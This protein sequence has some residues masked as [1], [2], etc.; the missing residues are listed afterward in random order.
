MA[1]GNSYSRYWRGVVWWGFCLF[2]RFTV[3]HGSVKALARTG[4]WPRHPDASRSMR[5]WQVSEKLRTPLV[6]L[7]C[8]VPKPIAPVGPIAAP[9][10]AAARR[11]RRKQR[12]ELREQIGSGGMGT[13]YRAFDREL[14]RTVAVKVLHPEL[15]SSL[16]NLLRLKRELVLASRVSDRHVVR[17]HDLGEIAG[18][19]LIAMDWVDGESL[20]A[21]LD[22]VHTLP[23][24]QVWNFA[25]QISQ[26]LKAIHTA[27]IVHRDLK[28]ANLLIARDGEILLT[29][30]GLAK[31]ALPQDFTLS[32]SGETSG[33]PRYMAPEQLAGLPADARSDLYSLGLVLL[34]MLTGTTA[35]ESLGG[36]RERLLASPRG[37]HALSEELRQFAALELVIRRC[38]Q[39]NRAERYAS[40]D[41][42]L[43]G[44]ALALREAAPAR[45]QRIRPAVFWMAAL[46]V[47]ALISLAMW[48]PWAPR[49][50][51]PRPDQLYAAAIGLMSPRAGAA[52]LTAALERLDQ[53]LG[54]HPDH[55]PAAGA[56]LDALIR[57]YEISGDPAWLR[58]ARHG[59]ATAAARKFTATQRALFQARIDL[60]DGMYREVIRRLEADTVL[61]NRSS[62]ANLLLGRA[63]EASGESDRALASYRIAVRL[64]PES[65]L[66]HNDLGSALLGLGR[67]EDARREFVRVT[68]LNPEEPTGYCNL[69]VSFLESGDLANAR[70]N[71][72]IALQRAPASE[73]YY[74]LGVTAYFAREYA[75]SIPFFES[76]IRIRPNFERYVLGLADA[77]RRSDRPGLARESYLHALALLDELARSRPLDMQEV[78]RRALCFAR[79]GDYAAAALALDAAADP[80][81]REI[82][83]ARAVLSLQRGQPAAAKAY[84]SRAVLR[85]YS[86][87]LARMDPDLEALSR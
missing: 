64:S 14:N 18:K 56:R 83:Y 84:L 85:G 26:A 79:L 67:F 51:S 13:I 55:V 9:S 81:H 43:G 62:E 47:P 50:S 1:I 68:Q 52:D 3:S 60:D 70:R 35:L 66:A 16:S 73:T 19:P 5:L 57:L 20:A 69:G 37:R 63:W 61:R 12:Y 33:T 23:A 11:L 76:A 27:H 6:L 58:K 59:L 54:A 30:F 39:A 53:V 72:E 87:A 71:F 15:T 40:V 28:P 49:G 25:G 10:P 46:V 65:W 21:L 38:L 86:P 41:E 77:L 44:L 2:P 22:R 31:S 45:K 75:T 8:M 24:S 32:S 42:V 82:L 34:E 4:P 7:N 48:R 80:D 74:N 36:F 78:A 17:V 29:D